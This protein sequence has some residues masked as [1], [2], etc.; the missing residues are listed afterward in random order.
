VLQTASRV[1]PDA[2]EIPALLAETLMRLHR[3]EEASQRAA[4][5]VALAERSDA[6]ALAAAHEIAARAALI[7]KDKDLAMAHA[8]QAQRAEPELP[9]PQFIRGRLLYDE[10]RYEEALDAFQ[11]AERMLMENGG[12]LAE[13]HHYLADTLARLDRFA[14]AETE[15]REELR[16]FPRAIQTYSSLAMLFRASN[17]NASVEQIIRDLMEAVPTPEGYALAARLWTILGE[18]SRAEALRLAAQARFRGDPS[19]ALLERQR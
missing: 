5:A 18:R 4:L 8:E 9:L 15:F 7:R 3:P 17:R 10:A 6:A 13:L 16:L 11:E 12:A 2:P 1:N 14:E 19:L